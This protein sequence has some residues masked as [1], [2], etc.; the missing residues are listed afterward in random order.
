MIELKNGKIVSDSLD[1]II[2]IWDLAK[3]FNQS[4]LT[5]KEHTWGVYT[6]IE[7]KI[8]KIV[9]GLIDFTIK[10]WDLAMNTN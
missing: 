1:F 3:N 7:L 5:L 10:I 8:G 6:L 9:S 4:I 2:K